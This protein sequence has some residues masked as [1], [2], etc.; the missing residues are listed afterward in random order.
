MLTPGPSHLLIVSVSMGNGFR[1][2]L[3]TT[4][5]DL[6]ANTIQIIL[7]GA[8]LAT[9]LAATRYGFLVVKWL[10]VAYLAWLGIKAI[11][12]FFSKLT[13]SRSSNKASLRELWVRGFITSA[14]NPKAVVFFA[15]LFPQFIDIHAPIV[16][17]VAILGITYILID[18]LFLTTYGIGASWISEK[19][20][21]Q[22]S[23][24]IDLVSGLGLLGAAALLGVKS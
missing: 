20:K 24:M 22:S 1:R 17:Q 3:A 2:S 10:G 14:A 16:G 15:A 21:T 6:S 5:G 19:L 13:N 12:K 4:A 8:G 9:L 23:K 18:G 11:L 7:A